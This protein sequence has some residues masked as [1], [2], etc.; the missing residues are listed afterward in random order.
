MHTFSF[1]TEA[2]KNLCYVYALNWPYSCIWQNLVGNSC[3]QIVTALLQVKLEILTHW[4]RTLAEK[5]IIQHQFCWPLLA[6]FNLSFLGGITMNLAMSTKISWLLSTTL[7]PL[8]SGFTS[9]FSMKLTVLP[10][11]P[12]WIGYIWFLMIIWKEL[13]KSLKN[14]KIRH[15]KG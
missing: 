7:E 2:G 14:S 8:C 5:S 9:K 6:Y 4:S 12:V 3:W 1:N 15:A 11:D 13:R 10:K